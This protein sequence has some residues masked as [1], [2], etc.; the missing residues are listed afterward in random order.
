[1]IKCHRFQQ[2][3]HIFFVTIKLN[4]GSF[5]SEIYNF[6]TTGPGHPP[7]SP[8]HPRL[9]ACHATPMYGYRISFGDAQGRE[10]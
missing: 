3:Y 5:L 9:R 8:I 6:K 4:S 1:M 7:D 10:L 2:I